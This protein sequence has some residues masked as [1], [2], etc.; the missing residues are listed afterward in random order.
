MNNNVCCKYNNA[1][2]ITQKI[3]ALK[4]VLNSRNTYNSNL[5]LIL[6]SS[7]FYK[8]QL[9]SLLYL[10]V[11]NLTIKNHVFATHWSAVF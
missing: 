4:T 5:L 2:Q 1:K 11:N 3:N 10:H 7:D 8:T 9:Y 6:Q